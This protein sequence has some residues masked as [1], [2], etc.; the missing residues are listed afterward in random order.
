V[1]YKQE[2]PF[3]EIGS[4]M[5]SACVST[6]LN[7]TAHPNYELM[8]ADEYISEILVESVDL[9]TVVIGEKDYYENFSQFYKNL[10]I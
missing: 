2:C 6:L 10:L 7:A 3:R 4:M 1:S 8:A 5:I 9:L